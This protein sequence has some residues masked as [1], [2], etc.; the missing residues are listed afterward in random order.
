MAATAKNSFLKRRLNNSLCQ[1]LADVK[2]MRD[3]QLGLQKNLQD[4]VVKPITFTTPKMKFS[5]KD[6]LNEFEQIRSF[7]QICSDL[8]KKVLT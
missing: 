5:F 1:V 8:L 3:W 2:Y 4:S 6:L 7:M